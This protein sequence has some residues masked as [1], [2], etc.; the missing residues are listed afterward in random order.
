[1]KSSGVNHIFLDID[2]VLV[3]WTESALIALGKDPHH[4]FKTWPNNMRDIAAVIGMD[5][6]EMW[7][8]L[9]SHGPNFWLE[10]QPRSY[11][12]ELWDACNTIAP[13]TILSSPTR[14]PVS[15]AG[16]LMWM[17][18]QFGKDFRSFLIGPAKHSCARPGALLIDDSVK[19]CDKFIEH[20][21]NAILFPAVHNH[22]RNHLH[23]P[24]K[25]VLNALDNVALVIDDDE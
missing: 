10:L 9:H 2:D 20:G 24:L 4:L 13:T 21:G 15:M 12:F 3:D 11:M 16:K 7:H 8:L 14:D 19:N 5:D 22:L 18:R 6:D 25:F 23:D 17:Q 1:M